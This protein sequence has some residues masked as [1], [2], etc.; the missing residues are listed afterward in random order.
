[1]RAAALHSLIAATG[2]SLRERTKHRPIAGPAR[3]YPVAREPLAY[4]ARVTNRRNLARHGL[5]AL[6]VLLFVLVLYHG[7]LGHFFSRDDFA[8]LLRARD[9]PLSEILSE[10][11]LQPHRGQTEWFWRPGWW[12][13]FD[14]AYSFFGL[15][16]RAYVAAG[17]LGHALVALLLYAVAARATG[18]VF[19]GLLAALLFAGSPAIVQGVVWPAAS[20]NVLPAAVLVFTGGLM[21]VRFLRSGSGGAALGALLLL[22]LSLLFREAAYHAPLALVGGWLVLGRGKR[23]SAKRLLV[24]LAF[25][26]ALVAFHY[27]RYTTP[28]GV[29]ELSP[30]EAL[31]RTLR[32]VPPALRLFV[33]GLPDG[34]LADGLLLGAA[35]L[36]LCALFTLGG[37]STRVFTIWS[38][39]A[40]FPYVVISPAP[41]LVYFCAM[42]FALALA[43]G[44]QEI[45]RRRSASIKRLAGGVL[46]AMAFAQTIPCSAEIERQSHE[47]EI[48]RKVLAECRALGLERFERLYVGLHPDPLAEIASML[49]LWFGGAREI[50]E[51][52]TIRRGA[53]LVFDLGIEEPR[54][55][56]E[57]EPPV[58]DPAAGFVEID[59]LA[60][61]AALR[62]HGEVFPEGVTCVPLFAF[63]HVASVVA[64]AGEAARALASPD[65][66][67]AEPVRLLEPSV[68]ALNAA[69][70]GSNRILRRKRAGDQAVLEVELGA[71]CLLVTGFY[72]LLSSAAPRATI[73]GRATRVLQADGL[74]HAIELARGSRVVILEAR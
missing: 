2:G 22:A 7:A 47:G 15:D 35:L 63:R 34:I 73:D 12:L 55:F 14:V 37:P 27:R 66:T 29:G 3:L 51:L 56:Y 61:S 19:H 58:A 53:L 33:P 69:E 11:L 54:A 17:I 71:D 48:A 8:L 45:A 13:L 59:P 25:L 50:R 44:S 21:L 32:N 24:V 42:P 10:Q 43:L 9:T 36:V 38:L 70:I 64:N 41:R 46:A 74:L 40:L 72:H 62:Q 6:V 1:M 4:A 20:F 52:L 60:G 67:P 31:V 30:V 39:A 23:T 65:W 26:L 18:S 49:R 5:A 16:P 28:T 68:L 57:W